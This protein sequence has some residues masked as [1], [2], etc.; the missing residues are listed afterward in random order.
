M[1]NC[2]QGVILQDVMHVVSIVIECRNDSL[3]GVD[4]EVKRDGIHIALV[5]RHFRVSSGLRQRRRVPVGVRFEFML[6]CSELLGCLL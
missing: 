2:R 6:S 1:M 3:T 4:L 5:A